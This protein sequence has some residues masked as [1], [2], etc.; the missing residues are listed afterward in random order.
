MTVDAIAPQPQG[1]A[2]SVESVESI[3]SAA[4][5]DAWQALAQALPRSL[6]SVAAADSG[7]LAYA[8]D[9]GRVLTALPR[10]VLAPRSAAEV[11]AALRLACRHR[12]AVA[13]RG[14]GHAASG[15]TL[16]RDGLV[17]D[18][19]ALCA[20]HPVNVEQRYVDVEGGASWA[21]V[22][23]ATLP[24]GLMPATTVDFQ[25][26]TVG[27]TLS[28]G[29]VGVQSFWAGVQADQVSELDVVSGAGELIACSAQA[30]PA[31]FDVARAGLGRAGAIVRA[32]LP[33]VCAPTHVRLHELF[34][35]STGELLADLRE[36][37]A[38]RPVDTL[39][40]LALPADSP[41]LDRRLAAPTVSALRAQAAASTTPG[42][43]Y[44]LEAGMY[45]CAR[46]EE[47]QLPPLRS[48]PHCR[49]QRQ[50]AISEF[51][52]RLPPLV[53]TEAL[54]TPP[55]PE[56]ILF[57]PEAS[58]EAL[59]TATLQEEDP[60]A[61]GGGPV[62]L[63]PI[64]FGGV[65]APQLR[66]PAAPRGFM[67]SLLRVAAP[68]TADR[69][70]AL[71]AT[72]LEIYKRAVAAGAV[73]YPCDALPIPA[74]DRARTEALEPLLARLDPAEVLSPRCRETT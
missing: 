40:A 6:R 20:V 45:L 49:L 71:T 42:W 11:Q 50:L 19:R 33:L 14:A 65:R 63:L 47:R 27:G 30:E 32:R 34:Y 56:L 1:T 72:N 55:H 74:F 31:V 70:R 25:Q 66:V 73:R 53:E 43:V 35:G 17:I 38:G 54:Y 39:L 44:R 29:G 18:M 23:A 13:L 46:Q 9:F 57:I 16:C 60:A 8:T 51:L 12:L 62:L 3:E 68:Q 10:A 69:V 22:L 21:Q 28:T 5:E 7:G 48:A 61:M 67:F 64:H 15:L 26:L 2:V 24:C 36:L 37:T 52:F 59:V 41:L 58:A 4:R